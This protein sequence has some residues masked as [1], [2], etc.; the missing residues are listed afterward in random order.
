MAPK[1]SQKHIVSMTGL[2]HHNSSTLYN[3]EKSGIAGKKSKVNL[4]KTIPIH[5]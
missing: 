3:N 4:L 2:K 5:P 1:V